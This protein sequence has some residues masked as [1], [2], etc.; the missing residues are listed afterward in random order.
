V[1]V[2]GTKQEIL[3]QIATLIGH[4]GW[5]V[6]SGS[7][8][9]RLALAEIAESI[10]VPISANESKRSIAKSIVESWGMEWYPTYESAGETITR[11]GLTAVLEAVTLAT[12][13]DER[14]IKEDSPDFLPDSDIVEI[15]RI[16]EMNQ[17]Y[18]FKEHANSDPD[19]E[20]SD[21]TKN[22]FFY[23]DS[24]N[25]ELRGL[26]PQAGIWNPKI[27][28]VGV[29]KTRTPIIFCTTYP[30]RAGSHDTPW[31]DQLDLDEGRALYFGDNKDPFCIDPAL[32]RGNRVMLENQVLQHSMVRE[33][34]E[35]AAPVLL[36]KAHG[37]DGK[38]YGFRTPIGLGVIW[39]SDP[40]MQ[41]ANQSGPLFPN[42]RFEIIL[43]DLGEDHAGIDMRWIHA[44]RNPE[45]SSRDANRFAPNAWRT[46]LD[47]GLQ[48]LPRLQIRDLQADI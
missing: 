24:R 35:L 36:I 31:H 7:T 8:E 12:K 21:G 26:R 23:T 22:W 25:P 29:R 13:K 6:S 30:D 9:P 39:R 38:D 14:I 45:Y 42:I 44:R 18:R 43:L 16:L 46:F 33:E 37:G 4:G 5:R 17:S 28:K 47:E 20:F 10:G 2:H 15:S 19:L 41:R 48:C 1:S 11:H 34:R 40:L 3:D 32:V 27:V